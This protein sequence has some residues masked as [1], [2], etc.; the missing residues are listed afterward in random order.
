MTAPLVLKIC[1]DCGA[2]YSVPASVAWC[3]A[4]CPDCR[5][6]HS[7]ELRRKRYKPSNRQ[8]TGGY[9]IILSPDDCWGR[10][11]EFDATNIAQTLHF[12]HFAPGTILE[13][14]LTRGVEIVEV[15]GNPLHRQSLNCLKKEE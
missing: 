12:G 5:Q 10:G 3:A 4:R 14:R 1:V 7:N 9:K 8:L 6:A 11:A 13:H 2:S 15:V